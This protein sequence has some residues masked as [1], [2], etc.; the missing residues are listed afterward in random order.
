MISATVGSGPGLGDPPN[1]R[2]ESR[3]CDGLGGREGMLMVKTKQ[4][5][6]TGTL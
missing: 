2:G 1:R 6:M 3:N 4:H 5:P